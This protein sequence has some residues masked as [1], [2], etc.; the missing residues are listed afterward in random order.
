MLTDVVNSVKAALYDRTSSPLFGAF[1]ISWVG[2]NYRLLL[3]ALSEGNYA[4]KL[5][6]ISGILYRSTQDYLLYFCG[7]PL[8]TAVAFIYL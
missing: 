3:V 6:Y 4:E 1:A 2:W 7:A 8:A 5:V